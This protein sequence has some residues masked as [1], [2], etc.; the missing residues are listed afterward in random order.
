M[1]FRQSFS[2]VR[3]KP[4]RPAK[5][6]V[7]PAKWSLAVGPVIA[8]RSDRCLQICEFGAGPKIECVGLIGD[9]PTLGLI[10]FGASRQKFYSFEISSR[11]RIFRKENLAKS[12]A[13]GQTG[14]VLAVR[15]VGAVRPAMRAV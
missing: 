14:H 9:L 10:F 8:W 6:A 7:R 5:L 4:V 11:V 12:L 2:S 15:P 1:R 3:L 13:G